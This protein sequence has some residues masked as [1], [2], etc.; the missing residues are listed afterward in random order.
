M[1][2]KKNDPIISSKYVRYATEL[3]N[4]WSIKSLVNPLHCD[5][6]NNH[7]CQKCPLSQ[8]WCNHGDYI[9]LKSGYDDMLIHHYRRSCSHQHKISSQGN[10][11]VSKQKAHVCEELNSSL[12]KDTFMYKYRETLIGRVEEIMRKAELNSEQ[13]SL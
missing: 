3:E 10:A 13:I 9:T 2:N 5:T 1:E 11:T 8:A 4:T 6:M 12:R 7:H